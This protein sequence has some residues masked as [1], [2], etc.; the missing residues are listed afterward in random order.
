MAKSYEMNLSEGS[1]FKKLIIYALPL[2]ATNV[3]QLLFNATDVAILGAFVADP[4]LA[5]A[6]VAAVGSTGALINLIVGLF[7]GLSIGVNV[8]VA[9][10][11][12][13]NDKARSGR[14]VGTAVLFGALVGC[15]LLLVG[16][17]GA[18]T[19][20]E[21]MDCDEE[22]IGM[23][24]KYLKIYFLGM[25][26]MML[27]NFAA[28]VLRA[29]GDTVRPL[30]YLVLGGVLNVGLNI[31]FVVVLKKDVE[32]VAIATV[33]AQLLS[34]ILAMIA[35]RKSDG[36]SRLEWKNVRLD[37]RELIEMAR[38]GVPA[39]LQSCMFSLANVLIQSSVNSFGKTVMAANT[40]SQQFEGF[41]W[42][43]MA[44]IS[45]ASIAFISQNLG[46]EKID[47]VRKTTFYA[48]LVVSIVWAAITAVV[49]PLRY[50]FCGIMSDSEE[51]VALACRRLSMIAL[52]YILGGWM[53]VLG[54]VLRGLGKSTVAMLIC[55]VGSCLFRIVWLKT[56]F[57]LYPTIETVWWVFPVSWLLTVVIYAFVYFPL[58]RRIE[59]Q[60][61]L[62]KENGHTM[63]ETNTYY[64][65]DETKEIN[66]ENEENIIKNEE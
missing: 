44:G 19:F 66:E 11:V 5:D 29:V 16:F 59:R 51:V 21:W 55:L 26:I 15:F 30:I 28:S 27:Y 6:A 7:V 47:R 12:G 60:Y 43:A 14:I 23:A 41:I 3:L 57:K 56:V 45:A 33:A 2:M 32:G 13:A 40:I 8:L 35:L 18:R 46:A 22:V 42:N 58:M 52:S 31:F 49:L 4:T 37:K 54:S 48:L 17:F 53:D 62:K 9:R 20:L 39:G 36:F 1:I 34:A 61:A 38:I 65:A 24:T 10:C 25:P 63:Y 64:S 50:F